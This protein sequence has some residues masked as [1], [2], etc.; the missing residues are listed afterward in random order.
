MVSY[1]MWTTVVENITLNGEI[2]KAG[3]ALAPI[4]FHIK[5]YIRIEL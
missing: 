5:S 1:K 4:I 3:V 2:L